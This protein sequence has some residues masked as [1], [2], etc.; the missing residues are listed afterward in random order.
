MDLRE[1]PLPYRVQSTDADEY[2][3]KS[4]HDFI[5]LRR[6][7]FPVQ[8]TEPSEPNMNI[9]RSTRTLTDCLDIPLREFH[10][11]VCTQHQQ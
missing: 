5:D 2:N 6:D 7:M 3:A 1:D 4:A 11:H 8:C 10:A 9:P